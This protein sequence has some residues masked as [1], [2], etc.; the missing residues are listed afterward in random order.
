M[1]KN[2]VKYWK[3]NPWKLYCNKN[4]EIFVI[5]IYIIPNKIVNNNEEHENKNEHSNNDKINKSQQI[6]YI[7]VLSKDSNY[8]HQAKNINKIINKKF[9]SMNQK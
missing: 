5:E 2:K 8:K 6:F 9:R 7:T 4:R 1:D 3:M